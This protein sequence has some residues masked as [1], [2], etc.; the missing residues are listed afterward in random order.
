[1]LSFVMMAKLEMF[2]MQM[3]IVRWIYSIVVRKF[4]TF[5]ATKVGNMLAIFV[6]VLVSIAVA[7]VSKRL[8]ITIPINNV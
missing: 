8:K 6:G 1:M 2:N 3:Y 5:P 7:V 4:K